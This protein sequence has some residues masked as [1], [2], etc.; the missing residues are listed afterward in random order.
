[1]YIS[2]LKKKKK[3]KECIFHIQKYT[4]AF[5][6]HHGLFDLIWVEWKVLWLVAEKEQK[7]KNKIK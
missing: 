4:M 6:E 5:D 2:F 7:Y 1:M 3:K